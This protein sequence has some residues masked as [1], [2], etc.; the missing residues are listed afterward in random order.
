MYNSTNLPLE[1]RKV[2]KKSLESIIVW[3][4]IVLMIVFFFSWM[5]TQATTPGTEAD[6]NQMASII[7][8]WTWIG[9]IAMVV[10]SIFYQYLYYKFYYY[11]F[12][13]DLAEIK[14]GVVSQATGHVNYPRIQNIY[15]DQ[16]ILDRIMGLY[17]V[18]YETAGESSAFYSHVDGLN[19]TNADKLVQFLLAK[20]K[21]SH[22]LPQ[23]QT[24]AESTDPAINTPPPPVD[25]ST[26]YDKNNLPISSIYT[27]LLMLQSSSLFVL[28]FV[29]FFYAS[30]TMDVKGGFF[31]LG[32]LL[33]V[34]IFV[35][36]IVR[37]YL[38]VKF[39]NYNFDQIK[40]T[41]TT[42]IVAR[43]T[44]IVYFNRIQN[45][46]IGQSFMERIFGLYN[47]SIETAG[48]S[49]TFS[50]S[51]SK[52]NE[53]SDAFSIPGL[54]KEEAEKLKGF[55]LENSKANRANI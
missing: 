46:N 9:Y 21:N 2:I 43:Q 50:G 47:L 45:I 16:D 55:L 4:L 5:P 53:E 10:L 8:N 35:F 32:I 23:N 36:N 41:L 38:W 28:I 3:L 6:I 49:A 13:E 25:L 26:V 54:K 52:F 40:G 34:A 31:N 29:Y 12:Q 39:L 20:T 33:L 14:K 48:E 37:A 19:K 7:K 30:S 15:L 11:N 51:A 44:K 18:H 27:L 22:G 17:D 24:V 1:P 42:G